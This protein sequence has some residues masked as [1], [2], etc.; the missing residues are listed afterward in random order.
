MK[1]KNTLIPLLL[2]G[3]A[4][5][6]SPMAVNGQSLPA[7]VKMTTSTP[8]GSTLTF[9]VDQAF[10]GFAV[11]WGDGVQVKY[12]TTNDALL[13]ITGE[14][15]G[16]DITIYGPSRWSTLICSGCGLT[17]L[18]LSQSKQLRSLY[19]QNNELETLNL[20]GLSD[21]TD[22]DCSD[23]KLKGIDYTIALNPAYDLKN[24]ECYNVS[25]N[26]LSGQGGTFQMGTAS[27]NAA[28]VSYLD[29][30]DNQFTKAN[31][32]APNAVYVNAGGNGLGY[33]DLSYCTKAQSI[34]LDNNKLSLSNTNLFSFRLPNSNALQQL[35][36]DKNEGVEVLDLSKSSSLTDLSIKNCNISSLKLYA[37]LSFAVF[38]ISGNNLGFDI[39][40][41][42]NRAPKYI[43]Y[44]R[45]SRY[46][47]SSAPG[48]AKT[49]EGI[50]YIPVCP[51]Y[52]DRN[53]KLYQIDLD[54]LRFNRNS[55]D[56]E[57]YSVADDGTA[58][59]LE[60][61][62][63]KDYYASSGKFSFFKPFKKVYAKLTIKRSV[64][65]GFT[66]DTSF[67]GV[68]EE[69]AA[70]GIEDVIYSGASVSGVNVEVVGGTIVLTSESAVALSVYSSDG[71][72]VWSGTV[73][74][75]PTTVSLPSGVYI[76]AGKK[77]AL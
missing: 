23:N 59:L 4:L 52:E 55:T 11:D 64:Y 66:Y 77:V 29:I 43:Q 68:G 41:D 70:T 53:N 2:L 46:D 57:W 25:G 40:P 36:L 58:T 24:I 37:G 6:A 10:G 71:K 54:N 19:C 32:Y 76:V 13:T 3:G 7:S 72:S 61:G 12:E 65:K 35:V 49:D 39:L 8:K 73:N 74:S 20:K 5:F 67:I 33:A 1:K 27:T 62:R 56:I 18:D 60:A 28:S 69:N 31:L 75:T 34:V 26:Q 16:A 51:S 30:S 44:S 15:K 21:L 9:I 42:E 50:A 48:I 14:V 17:S 47:I 45:A 38:D 22:L 63:D